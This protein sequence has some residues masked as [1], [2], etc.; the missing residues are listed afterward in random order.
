MSRRQYSCGPAAA[1]AELPKND[2]QAIAAAPK[3]QSFFVFSLQD[4]LADSRGRVKLG[5]PVPLSNL[6]KDAKS[7]SPE[8][9]ST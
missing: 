4:L 9:T 8:T 3:S 1:G 2:A 7:G 5:H 6:S